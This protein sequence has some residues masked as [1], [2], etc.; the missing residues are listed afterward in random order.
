MRS[1][2]CL[3][4][5][6]TLR[7]LICSRRHLIS[8]IAIGVGCSPQI[9]NLEGRMAQ[10]DERIENTVTIIAGIAG[11]LAVFVNLHLKD[12]GVSNTLEA[13]KD[14]AEFIVV[15][16][17]FV[18]TSRLI[19][20]T[21]PADFV[22]VFEEGLKSWV[23]QNDYL[24]SME[25]DGSG[26]GKFGTRFCSMLIDHSN[27]VTHRKRAEHASHNIEKATFVRL[28]SVGVDEIEFRFNERTFARQ[29]IFRKGEDVDLGAIIEQLSNRIRETFSSYPISLRS[30]RAKKTIFV[31]FADVDRT[32]ANARML[33]DVIEYV[34][35][36]TLALA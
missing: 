11:A 4:V 32:P 8:Q 33:V 36:M 17:V 26:Q 28:P 15:I 16:A 25:L 22:E 23:S 24:I 31:S 29:Q 14:V 21:K 34:K 18:L 27:I 3:I 6:R 1:I 5:I 19:R 10:A 30:D 35:T 7:S 2:G 13:I 12:Y 9:V 20:R